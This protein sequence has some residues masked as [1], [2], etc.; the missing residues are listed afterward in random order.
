MPPPPSAAAGPRPPRPEAGVARPPE[1]PTAEAAPRPRPAAP[2]PPVAPRPPAAL[3]PRPPAALPPRPPDGPPRPPDGP[4]RPPDGPPRSSP[5]HSVLAA[6]CACLSASARVMHEATSSRSSALRA[7]L[8]GSERMPSSTRSAPSSYKRIA[9]CADALSCPVVYRLPCSTASLSV[10]TPRSVLGVAG[11]GAGAARGLNSLRPACHIGGALLVFF[12]SSWRS[13]FRGISADDEPRV[14]LLRCSSQ[15]TRHSET[16][17]RAKTRH[18]SNLKRD[19]RCIS[20]SRC[21]GS[22]SLLPNRRCGCRVAAAAAATAAPPL[23]TRCRRRSDAERDQMQKEPWQ[24][25]G[26]LTSAVCL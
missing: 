10:A 21:R 1:R 20:H 22:L 8:L 16:H 4:L 7:S 15:A 6:R 25:E 14:F 5:P 17:I 11:G 19:N 12:A 18:L 26:T 23:R 13:G 3:P 2:R 9:S 24:S